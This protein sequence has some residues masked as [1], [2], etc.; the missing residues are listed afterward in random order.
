[1]LHG[2]Q[3][4][5]RCRLTLLPAAADVVDRRR[6]AWVKQLPLLV[7]VGVECVRSGVEIEV[8]VRGLGV[9]SD[10]G[11]HLLQENFL[12]DFVERDCPGALLDGCCEGGRST[13]VAR[14]PVE[15]G[16]NFLF[17][18][19]AVE[20]Q[21]VGPLLFGGTFEKL[22]DFR[23]SVNVEFS[24]KEGKFVFWCSYVCS[25][26]SAVNSTDPDSNVLFVKSW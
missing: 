16:I 12:L 25:S 20:G 22:I 23:I 21:E 3:K 10:F 4:W 26:V 6:V 18:G 24:F 9:A 11:R 2:G 5:S 1:M 19:S 15:N 17:F 7:E 14:R 8:L 13:T